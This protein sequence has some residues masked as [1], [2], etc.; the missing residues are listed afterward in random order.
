ME[1]GVERPVQRV[2]LRQRYVILI[3]DLSVNYPLT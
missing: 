2:V 3:P 1:S